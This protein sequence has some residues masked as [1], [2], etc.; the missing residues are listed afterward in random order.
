MLFAIYVA[1]IVFLFFYYEKKL[2]A[3]Q[4]KHREEVAKLLQIAESERKE[5]YDRIM[6]KDLHVYKAAKAEPKKSNKP[7]NFLKA[8][9]DKA[10]REG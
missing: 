7:Q 10:Y 9:I 1:T 2:S 4:N 6:S 8:Q 3:E 5:L